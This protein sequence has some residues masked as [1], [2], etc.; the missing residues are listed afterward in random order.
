MWVVRAHMLRVAGAF[1]LCA[2]PSGCGGSALSVSWTAR[3][4]NPALQGQIRGLIGVVRAQSCTGPEM[5]RTEW[6]RGRQGA[7]P[8]V[9]DPGT[10]GFEVLALD[11]NCRVVASG[12][13][14][15]ILENDATA[16][17]TSLE[18]ST[19]P[20]ECG[21]AMCDD[22]LCSGRPDAG[23]LDDG[24]VLDG[25]VADGGLDGGPTDAGPQPRCPPTALVCETFDA[26]PV[27]WGREE[28]GGGSVAI[29]SARSFAGGASLLVTVP[30][31]ATARRILSLDPP[32]ME[33]EFYARFYAYLE[34]TPVFGGFA[35]VFE[36]FDTV[37]PN[38]TSFEF[39]SDDRVQV[40][41]SG[42][43][44]ESSSIDAFPRGQWICIQFEGRL[45]AG[46]GDGFVRV[47]VDGRAKASTRIGADTLSPN[48]FD[49]LRFGVASS[50][51]NGAMQFHLDELAVDD[52][53]VACLPSP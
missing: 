10:Y 23:A 53:P 44:F 18:A 37:S 12:C 41:A 38:K 26:E 13:E 4:A 52:E 9:L 27:G 45:E 50:A 42:G 24:G 21:Q 49:E 7:A 14:E 47:I 28:N 25:A 35:V 2:S 40:F 34:P 20:A 36:L 6:R 29:S 15:V 51:A 22:G 30:S 8:P 46:G 17:V 11:E 31:G 33:R 3:V 43:E 1:L 48:G 39:E 16:I 32:Y 19:A 5:F